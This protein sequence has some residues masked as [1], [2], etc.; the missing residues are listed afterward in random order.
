MDWKGLKGIREVLVHDYE[1]VDVSIL[2]DVL[3]TELPE[4][5]LAVG[6]LLAPPAAPDAPGTA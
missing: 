4:L 5:L 3:A 6:A 1:E 2:E